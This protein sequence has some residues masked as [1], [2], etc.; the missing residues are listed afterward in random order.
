MREL[1][2]SGPAM[3][4]LEE[5]AFVAK[6]FTRAEIR[7]PPRRGVGREAVVAAPANSIAKLGGCVVRVADGIV[8]LAWQRVCQGPCIPRA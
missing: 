6:H 5:T 2:R 8:V 4:T 7:P 1:V 3:C